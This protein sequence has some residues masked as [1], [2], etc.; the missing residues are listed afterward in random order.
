MPELPEVET[1]RRDL[2][3]E[4]VGEKI[5][6][7]DYIVPKMLQPNPQ[8]VVDNTVGKTV[9][10]FSRIA[11]ML[12]INLKEGGHV[13]IHLKLSGQL[14]VV[15][16]KIPLEKY[17][18]VMINFDNGQQIR[19][20]EMRKFGYVK[21]IKDTSSLD[22]ILNDYGPEPLT[23]QFTE[24]SFKKVLKSARPIKVVIMDQKKVAGVGNIYADE[25]L[26]YSKIHPETKANKLTQ[27]EIKELFTAIN[28]VIKQ[29]IDDRG[30]SI[31]SY[32]DGYGKKGGH[33]KNLQVFR[34]DK[35]PCSRCGTIIQKS[36]VGGRGTHFCPKEQVY[37]N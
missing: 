28:L 18:Y 25:A 22:T 29:G 2:Q 1:I 32:L 8:I 9:Q 16:Q 27:K 35:K 21:Y 34:R 13:G 20:N 31:D 15:D 14:Y 7:I 30:T 4:L 12:L 36:R 3:K 26:W 37:H 24:E 10:S 11:K 17:S 33:D 6:S 5:I 19:F 23:P